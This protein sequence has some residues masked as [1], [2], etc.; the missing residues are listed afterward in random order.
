MKT[1]FFSEK[2][3]LKFK[4][5]TLKEIMR[6]RR[7]AARKE[8]K[9]RSKEVVKRNAKL[10]KERDAEKKKL[11]V[12]KCSQPSCSGKEIVSSRTQ[13]VIA[14]SRC[15]KE[16]MNGRRNDEWEGHIEKL[17]RKKL[18]IKTNVHDERSD[19][20]GRGKR[21]LRNKRHSLRKTKR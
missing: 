14:C 3:W 6:E 21:S 1:H 13:E 10:A 8:E 20:P 18:E 7:R 17:K 9:K 2:E 11:S 4:K 15:T 5:T 16:I 19:K 12:M